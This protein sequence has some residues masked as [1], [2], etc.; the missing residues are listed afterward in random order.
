MRVG[1]A[2]GAVGRAVGAVVGWRLGMSV[3]D[4]VGASVGCGVG[5]GVETC[6]FSRLSSEA[7]PLCFRA[8][9]GKCKPSTS[10]LSTGRAPYLDCRR[11]RRGVRRLW[12]IMSGNE[13]GARTRERA[14]VRERDKVREGPAKRANEATYPDRRGGRRPPRSVGSC[15]E[16]L[17]QEYEMMRHGRGLGRSFACPNVSR[18][19]LYYVQPPAEPPHAQTPFPLATTWLEHSPTWSDP[20]VQRMSGSSNNQWHPQ[21]PDQG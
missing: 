6:V 7:T 9:A 3:G 17:E 12:R 21:C 15:K 4:V 5:S 19:S 8:R 11:H 18:Q 20:G 2:V 14:R 16:D 13:E 10:R 1:D